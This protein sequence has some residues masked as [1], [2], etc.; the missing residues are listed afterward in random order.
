MQRNLNKEN[1]AN[2]SKK[3]NYAN[4]SKKGIQYKQLVR[5]ETE[6]SLLHLSE[7]CWSSITPT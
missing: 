5:L 6:Q 2:K 3:V 4:K 7:Q 1:Y